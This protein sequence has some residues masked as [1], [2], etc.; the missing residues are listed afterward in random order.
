MD[1]PSNVGTFGCHVIMSYLVQKTIHRRRASDL[2]DGVAD[3]NGRYTDR[4]MSILEH[5]ETMCALEEPGSL[6][7]MPGLMRFDSSAVLKMVYVRLVA[8]YAPG[9][10]C[11]DV[12]FDR[13]IV[14]QMCAVQPLRRGPGTCKAALQACLALKL[15]AQLGFK[16][17]A[18]TKFRVWSV[19]HPI[20]YFEC[21]LFLSQWISAM[22]D[23]HDATREEEQVLRM[24]REVIEQ[25]GGRGAADGTSAA[26]A[27]FG[28]GPS[29][30]I[31]ILQ[32]CGVSHL[33]W[34]VS[35]A[36]TVSP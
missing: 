23:A 27:F 5:W 28:S 22:S 2:L 1:I 15:P 29:R 10:R 26:A 4:M 20:S 33:S 9:R 16:M 11:F 32:R 17:V 35:Y 19:Q 12:L 24:L 6:A 31:L 21:A 14:D 36:C 25:T 13:D 3:E 7:N 18:R 30:S 34:L 8:D